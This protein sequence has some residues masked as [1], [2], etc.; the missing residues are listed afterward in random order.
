M[1]TW[2]LCHQEI[3]FCAQDVISCDSFNSAWFWLFL[4][5]KDT[6]F[7]DC[8]DILQRLQPLNWDTTYIYMWTV[9]K[10]SKGI[11]FFYGMCASVLGFGKAAAFVAGWLRRSWT[12]K[13]LLL[14]LAFPAPDKKRHKQAKKKNQ[15]DM[16]LQFKFLLRSLCAFF[17]FSAHAHTVV[18]ASSSW[19]TLRKMSVSA[20]KLGGSL[21]Q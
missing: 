13:P 6:A 7:A 11:F 3:I 5:T 18:N 9:W 16:L 4:F 14:P 17:P 21:L 19:C 15:H 20:L 2:K 8:V 12:Q 10:I 1:L